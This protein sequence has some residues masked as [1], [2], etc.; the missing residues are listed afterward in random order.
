[1]RALCPQLSPP[2]TVS[3]EREWHTRWRALYPTGNLPNAISRSWGGSIDQK[4]AQVLVLRFLWTVHARE[5]GSECPWG[6]D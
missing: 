2:C 6:L 5:T 3:Q 1:M 4:A